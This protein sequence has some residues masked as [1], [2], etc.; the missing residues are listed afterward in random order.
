MLTFLANADSSPR[1]VYDAYHLRDE[2]NRLD[3]PVD[4][5]FG[6]ANTVRMMAGEQSSEAYLLLAK[7]DLDGVPSLN[8]QPA[9]LAIKK[10]G[11]Y[12][13]KIRLEGTLEGTI[14]YFE[15]AG[16]G[17]HSYRCVIGSEIETDKEAI[18]LV[19]FCDARHFFA[20][21]PCRVE[22]GG[23]GTISTVRTGYNVVDASHVLTTTYNEASVD[24]FPYD[25][26]TCREHTPTSQDTSKRTPYTWDSL[27]RRLW[28]EI[29][30]NDPNDAPPIY[31]KEFGATMGLSAQPFPTGGSYPDDITPGIPVPLSYRPI[32]IRP[33]NKT[34]WSLFC[35]LLHSIGNE[36]YPLYN[37][38]FA[39]APIDQ[40]FTIS[41]TNSNP[42][43]IANTDL[44]AF[45]STPG[46]IID[47]GHAFPEWKRIPEKVSMSFFRRLSS[48]SPEIF[49]RL[50]NANNY[51]ALGPFNTTDLIPGFTINAHSGEIATGTQVVQSTIPGTIENFTTFARPGDL[52]NNSPFAKYVLT[53]YLKA[54]LSPTF[55]ITLPMHVPSTPQPFY[56]EV[57][58]YFD[59]DTSIDPP[60][61]SPRTH[62]LTKA[63]PV[64]GVESVAQPSSS[65]RTEVVAITANIPAA[66]WN[67][68]KKPHYLEPVSVTSA[69]WYPAKTNAPTQAIPNPDIVPVGAT[70][71]DNRSPPQK[72]TKYLSEYTTTITVTSGKFRN[73]IVVDGILTNV[74][75]TENDMPP[76]SS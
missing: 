6:K 17:F 13:H 41:P 56:S 71:F 52:D 63:P 47:D 34:T 66:V 58:Y 36:I 72:T 53:R 25:P 22:I 8:G 33:E 73:G 7:S 27:L 29:V 5:W 57:L 67:K 20:K 1:Y 74:D 51:N 46:F 40:S 49:N 30:T 42:P 64:P 44:A 12:N 26:D 24:T 43:T 4:W 28:H 15:I 10:A 16:W 61:P 19:R 3:V 59:L 76:T 62:F 32:D 65:G 37:G 39:I 18:F 14:P 50:K 38:T 55:D 45:A 48:S 70:T 54:C 35:D 60:T 9:I 68:D 69:Y 75:C 31:P 11:F 21:Q 23:Q 2:C